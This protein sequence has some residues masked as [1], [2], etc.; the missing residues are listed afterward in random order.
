MWLRARLHSVVHVCRRACLSPLV[1]TC[2]IASKFPLN[3]RAL[4]INRYIMFL[5]TVMTTQR[6]SLG[7]RLLTSLYCWFNPALVAFKSL[8]KC[9]RCQNSFVRTIVAKPMRKAREHLHMQWVFFEIRLGE[10]VE[11]AHSRGPQKCIRSFHSFVYV[12]QLTG[13]S[14]FSCYLMQLCL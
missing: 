10:C 12:C 14:K 6:S 11:N 1:S 9:R 7:N 8:H 13:L 2:N 5:E 3:D 4:R